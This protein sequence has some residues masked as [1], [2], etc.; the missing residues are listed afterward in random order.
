LFPTVLFI[1]KREFPA[2]LEL[3]ED[4]SYTLDIIDV[5]PPYR[6]LIGF[7][8]ENLILIFPQSSI[9]KVDTIFHEFLHW[10]NYKFL[11]NKEWIDRLID[12]EFRM[13]E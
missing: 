11:D 7:C 12:L 9:R 3:N 2:I 6:F 13:E 10:I 4:G 1:S 8:Y 5:K